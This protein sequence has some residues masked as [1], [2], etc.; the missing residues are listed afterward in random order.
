MGS[1][2]TVCVSIAILKFNFDAFFYWR[3]RI[4]GIVSQCILMLS[5]LS[6]LNSLCSSIRNSSNIVRANQNWFPP[7]KIWIFY[8]IP[9]TGLMNSILLI[10]RSDK[11]FECQTVWLSYRCALNARDFIS[12]LEI[13]PPSYRPLHLWTEVT[14]YSFWGGSSDKQKYSLILEYPK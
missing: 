1:L 14:T 3:L 6:R 10:E 4:S 13:L 9:L 11:S 8:R 5:I 2:Q 12:N 7:N